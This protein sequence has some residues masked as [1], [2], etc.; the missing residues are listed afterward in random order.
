[1]TRTSLF[2]ALFVSIALAE[3]AWQPSWQKDWVIVITQ[4]NASLEWV[5][6]LPFD[7]HPFKAR[8]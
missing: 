4:Y 7:K 1:M 6:L 3:K 2:I 8:G 5:G